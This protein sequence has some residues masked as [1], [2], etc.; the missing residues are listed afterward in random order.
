MLLIL[1]TNHGDVLRAIECN[2]ALTVEEFERV[3]ERAAYFNQQLQQVSAV[4]VD[5][6]DGIVAAINE[7][8][9][10]EEDDDAS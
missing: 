8:N 3:H 9:P 4:H 1:T 2:R 7:A 6:A 10:T 5:D